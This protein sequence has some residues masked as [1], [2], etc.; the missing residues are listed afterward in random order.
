MDIRRYFH[1]RNITIVVSVAILV[2][3]AALIIASAVHKSLA[4]SVNPIIEQSDDLVRQGDQIQVNLLNGCGDQGVARR[5]M[6]YL[7]SSG[8]DVVEIDNYS[9]FSVQ[10]SFVIDRVGDSLSA[11]KTA[12]ALG[13]ADSL[14]VL[15]IDSTLY[16]RASVVIGRDYRT[17]K[18][19]Q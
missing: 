9:R 11:M 19:F 3:F 13:I 2:G 1:G 16:I 14:R 17:L 6:N 7:R 5:M 12:K 4:P 15:R 8:F 10:R 18:P